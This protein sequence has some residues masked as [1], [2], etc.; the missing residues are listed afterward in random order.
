M[1]VKSFDCPKSIRN[2]ETK[3]NTWNVKRLVDDLFVPLA[4]QTSILYSRLADFI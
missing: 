4:H 3:K 2:Y 1:K